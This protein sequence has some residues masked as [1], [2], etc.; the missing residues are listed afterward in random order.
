MAGYP[1]VQRRHALFDTGPAAID[2]KI[3]SQKNKVSPVV[4]SMLCVV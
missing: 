1:D 4:N 3:S 2:V